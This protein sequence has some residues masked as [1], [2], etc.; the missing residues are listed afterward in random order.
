MLLSYACLTCSFFK[1]F[2]YLIFILHFVYLLFILHLF[3]TWELFQMVTQVAYVTSKTTFLLRK[4]SNCCAVLS[5]L[6]IA[7]LPLT[8]QITEFI[9]NACARNSELPSNLRFNRTLF[10][11]QISPQR[12]VPTHGQEDPRIQIRPEI[13]VVFFSGSDFSENGPGSKNKD[14]ANRFFLN[15]YL[16]IKPV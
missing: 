5:I 15:I 16:L 6:T 2:V 9:L 1:L 7:R 4:K 12:Y 10:A 3:S 13:T 11:I 14:I 8:D